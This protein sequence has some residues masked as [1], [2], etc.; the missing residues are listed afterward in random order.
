MGSTE[1]LIFCRGWTLKNSWR[2]AMADSAIDWEVILVA[3]RC[4]YQ[5]S[6]LDEKCF[7]FSFFTSPYLP[8]LLEVERTSI[9]LNADEFRYRMVTFRAE[10]NPAFALKIAI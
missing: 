3:S 4:V 10:R 6:V 7:L 5:E 1:I 8:P 9:A 2:T